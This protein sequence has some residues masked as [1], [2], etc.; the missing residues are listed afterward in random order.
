MSRGA[1]GGK[2]RAQP[3][4]LP[5]K[6]IGFV[7]LLAG[8]SAP[9]ASDPLE[10]GIE[11]FQKGQY[12]EAMES[13]TLAVQQNPGDTQPYFYRALILSRVKDSRGA[14]EDYSRVLKLKPDH[15]LALINRCAALNELQQ[16]REARNDCDRAMH[17]RRPLSPAYAH[18]CGSWLYLGGLPQALADCNRAIALDPANAIAYKYRGL[19]FARQGQYTPAARD[20][21]Q[22]ANLYRQQ[23][24]LDRY[25]E[26][27]AAL[28]SLGNDQP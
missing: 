17:F 25:R 8:C 21:Q 16:Y 5:G 11:Q 3:A 12:S 4:L 13:L 22:A 26:V 2:I 7:L 28:E 23:Q 6:A 14:V 24:D 18:R 19:V 27:Q 10:L 9:P 1:W 20:L 15:R